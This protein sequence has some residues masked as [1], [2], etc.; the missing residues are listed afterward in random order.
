MLTMANTNLMA[1]LNR[2][3]SAATVAADVMAQ[4]ADP[5]VRKAM[6]RAIVR[7]VGERGDVSDIASDAMVKCIEAASTYDWTKGEIVSW[8]CRIASNTARNEARRSCNNG[9]FS[10]VGDEESGEENATDLLVAEDGRDV[11][12]RRSAMRALA[13]AM[14]A[15]DADTQ[16]VLNA[17]AGGASQREA[18]MLV[19]WTPVQTT[20]KLRR[21]FATLSAAL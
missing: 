2:N 13:V 19:G 3:D 17:L 1:L 5:S 12:E 20:R 21:V 8:A 18:G 9:H 6:E 10:V 11:I 16:L 7:A 4:L 15:L 14:G